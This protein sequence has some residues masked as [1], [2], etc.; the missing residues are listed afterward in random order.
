MKY[1]IHKL[2]LRNAYVMYATFDFENEAEV[3]EVSD[4]LDIPI[5]CK[6]IQNSLAFCRFDGALQSS[7]D[8]SIAHRCYLVAFSDHTTHGEM[9]HEC[10]HLVQ[11]LLYSINAAQ[12]EACPKSYEISSELTAYLLMEI[13]NQAA[14]FCKNKGVEIRY[15]S[16]HKFKPIYPVQETFVY[17]D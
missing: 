6:D 9:A 12:P 14:G 13:T 11:E 7:E 17:N 8:K 10:L 4:M 3:K 5:D 16:E 2:L 1:E 15:A